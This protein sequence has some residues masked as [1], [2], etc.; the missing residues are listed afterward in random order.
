[1]LEPRLGRGVTLRGRVTG[2]PD[3]AGLTVMAYRSGG[4]V[5]E[6]LVRADLTFELAG[7]GLGK[8][9]V[10]VADRTRRSRGW[11]V[12]VG[13][14][15]LEVELPLRAGTGSIRTTVQG[16]ATGVVNLSPLEAVGGRLPFLD[17]LQFRD[18]GFVVDGLAPGRYRLVVQSLQ[19]GPESSLEVVV[20]DGEVA[21]TIECRAQR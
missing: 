16:C 14:V 2:S 6:G 3:A 20:G 21:V 1:M 13:D 8:T 11:R 17:M 4:R 9:H 12:E 19:G 7:L 5:V 10:H 15:D 18:S